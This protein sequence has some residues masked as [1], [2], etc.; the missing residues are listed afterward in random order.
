[1]SQEDDWKVYETN[2]PFLI[3]YG[4]GQLIKMGKLYMKIKTEMKSMKDL[5]YIFESHMMFIM[6]FQK[7]KFINPFSNNINGNKKC[8]KMKLFI[9]LAYN[10]SM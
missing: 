3:Y 8:H 4:V 7:S 6:P 1:M 9:P 5:I 10:N 2:S